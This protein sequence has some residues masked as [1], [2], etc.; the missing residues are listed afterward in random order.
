MGNQLRQRVLVF[1]KLLA[2]LIDARVLP[3]A[4]ALVVILEKKAGKIA[5]PPGIGGP[6]RREVFG[7]HRLALLPVGA[8]L[9]QQIAFD[10]P[11]IDITDA[12]IG[13]RPLVPGAKF[14]PLGWLV[15]VHGLAPV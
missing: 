15:I 8:L 7:P 10:A 2:V 3:Q 6:A 11:G 14:N 1:G 4:A 5:V 12:R 9:F 13:V